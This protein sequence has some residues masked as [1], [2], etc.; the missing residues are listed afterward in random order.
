[1]TNASKYNLHII[2]FVDVSSTAAA[3]VGTTVRQ[4]LLWLQLPYIY[5][6]LLSA[7]ATPGRQLFQQRQQ[8]LP[9]RP[10]KH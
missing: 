5:D 1:M 9:K 7:V 8:R 10:Q 2:V 4:V 3:F 6:Y